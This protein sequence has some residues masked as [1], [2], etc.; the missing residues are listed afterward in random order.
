MIGK[1]MATLPSL[2]NLLHVNSWSLTLAAYLSLSVE[3]LVTNVIEPMKWGKSKQ[4]VCYIFGCCIPLASSLPFLTDFAVQSLLAVSL[5]RLA[6]TQGRGVLENRAELGTS[7][8]HYVS[9]WVG[10]AEG[11]ISVS[12]HHLHVVCFT[13]MYS[14]EHVS[15]QTTYVGR[16]L[17]CLG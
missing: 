17:V 7:S 1:G 13:P 14:L 5:G 4:L 2:A 10:E 9:I 6:S 12:W 11:T 3:I 8:G 15:N 16:L